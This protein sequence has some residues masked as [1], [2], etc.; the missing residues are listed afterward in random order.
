MTYALRL[1]LLALGLSIFLSGCLIGSAPAP[2]PSARNRPVALAFGMHVAPHEDDNPIDPPERFTGYHAGMDYEVLASELDQEV[3]VFAV[4]SGSVLYSGFAEGYGGVLVQ[5]CT[6]GDEAVTALYGHLDGEGL[7][8]EGTNVTA[9]GRL[10]TLASA[11][12]FWSG[13]NR[14]HL[15]LGIHRGE[16]VD[17]RG[18][19]AM[20]IDLQDF[21]DP[22]VVLPRGA[23]G[24]QV[25][26]YRV[27]S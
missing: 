15:H 26:K 16:T 25:S 13:E 27:P 14:K 11:R 8:A 4:C 19:V 5:R 12:S 23:R 22:R 1:F 9:G 24:R 10:G 3:P 7:V 17:M 20:P 6:I 18:Y 21:I 2:L